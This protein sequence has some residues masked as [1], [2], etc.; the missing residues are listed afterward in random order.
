M[1][2]ERTPAGRL[3]VREFTVG[4]STEQ[5]A[6]ASRDHVSVLVERRVR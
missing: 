5:L 1:K 2:S 6:P 4:G 3:T